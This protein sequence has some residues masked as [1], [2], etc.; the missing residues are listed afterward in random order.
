MKFTRKLENLNTK[1]ASEKSKETEPTMNKI[2]RGQ[3]KRGNKR[4]LSVRR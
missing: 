4:K 3:K 2:P 1:I